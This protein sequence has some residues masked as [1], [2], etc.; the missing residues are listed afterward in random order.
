M[1][2]VWIGFWSPEVHFAVK[3]QLFNDRNLN[4]ERSATI[5]LE[6]LRRQLYRIQDLP[7]NLKAEYPN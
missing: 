5:A 4:K 1:G 7:Y 6:I 2:T 3:A